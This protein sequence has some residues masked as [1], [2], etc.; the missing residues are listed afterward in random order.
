MPGA[1]KLAAVTTALCYAALIVIV[2]FAA[3]YSVSA[4]A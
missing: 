2:A 1:R 4:V 3:V